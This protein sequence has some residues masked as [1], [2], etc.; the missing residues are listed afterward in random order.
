[1]HSLKFFPLFYVAANIQQF[2]SPKLNPDSNL[3]LRDEH[4]NQGM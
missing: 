3:Q 1:M 2:Q 4:A